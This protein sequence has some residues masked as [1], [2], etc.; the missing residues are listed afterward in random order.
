MNKPNGQSLTQKRLLDVD[1]YE[2]Y[3]RWFLELLY[4]MSNHDETKRPDFK[5]LKEFIDKTLNEGKTY[6][7]NNENVQINQHAKN[8][9]KNNKKPSQ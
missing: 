5:Q 4:E 7:Q 8:I 3:D 6:K 2:Y 9:A 1:K